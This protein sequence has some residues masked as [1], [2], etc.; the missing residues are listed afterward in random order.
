MI[1]STQTLRIATKISPHTPPG[2]PWGVNAHTWLNS[3]LRFGDP[4][5]VEVDAP[6]AG[7]PNMPKVR[8]TVVIE[9]GRIIQ[10]VPNWDPPLDMEI[11]RKIVQWSHQHFVGKT[12]NQ[13]ITGSLTWSIPKELN[14][15]S[16]L[17]LTNPDIM[18]DYRDLKK[19]FSAMTTQS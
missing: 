5:S 14:P 3:R 17:G 2:V 12:L 15:R 10:A 16:N 6:L 11:F 13:V 1:L 7:V 9:D 4:R 18:K 19:H 8:L